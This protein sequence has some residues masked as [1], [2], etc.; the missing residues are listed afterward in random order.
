MC[1]HQRLGQQF[2][3]HVH[4]DITFLHFISIRALDYPL[5]MYNEERQ[6]KRLSRKWK[7]TWHPAFSHADAVTS[8]KSHLKMV[9]WTLCRSCFVA[10]HL[11]AV[12]RKK[13]SFSEHRGD[14]SWTRF[15]WQIV[16]FHSNVINLSIRGLYFRYG[17]CCSGRRECRQIVMSTFQ[18][19]RKHFCHLKSKG[20]TWSMSLKK[21]CLLCGNQPPEWL[22]MSPMF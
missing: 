17:C 6:S 13:G 16:F 8:Q 15:T 14:Y 19:W 2:C 7:R 9:G 10:V 11:F 21:N 1:S 4:D 18:F 20:I 3:N 12:R 5:A 22:S